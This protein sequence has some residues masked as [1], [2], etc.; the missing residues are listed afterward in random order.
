MKRKNVLLAGVALA[1]AVGGILPVS[2][3]VKSYKDIKYPTLN[4]IVI[5]HVEKVELAN[6]MKLYLVEDHELPIINLSARVRVGS[7]FEPADKVGLAGIT[8]EVMRTGGTATRTGDEL[9]DELESLAASVETSI[10]ETSGRAFMSVLKEDID[11]GVAILADVLM[12]PEFRE[13]KL[14]LAKVEAK[15]GI[16]RRNDDPNGI[17]TREFGRIIY[18]KDSPY[19]RIPEYDT[20][21]NISR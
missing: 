21:E 10:G 20:I 2:A 15:S 16:S 4:E 9:D 3:Q 8:G 19:A 18:G 7:I 1:V 14:D 17:V 12:N 11:I 6:G 13:D 5:P